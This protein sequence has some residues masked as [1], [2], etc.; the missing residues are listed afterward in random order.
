MK[1]IANP[2]VAKALVSCP[3]QVRHKLMALRGLIFLTTAA[4]EGVG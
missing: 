1:S 2:A 3:T 4:T